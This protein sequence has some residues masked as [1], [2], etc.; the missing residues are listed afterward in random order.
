MVAK[1]NEKPRTRKEAVKVE[2]ELE[3]P[4]TLTAILALAGLAKDVGFLMMIQTRPLLRKQRLRRTRRRENGRR[5]ARLK[6][7]RRLKLQARKE[8]AVAAVVKLA[9]VVERMAVVAAVVATT[10]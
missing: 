3:E 8:T 7:L 1:E 4:A 5:L 9:A 6:L 2:M 10:I